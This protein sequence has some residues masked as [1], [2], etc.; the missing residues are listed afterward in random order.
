[1]SEDNVKDLQAIRYSVKRDRWIHTSKRAKLTTPLPTSFNVLTWNVQ[2]DA[3][4]PIRRLTR[5]L[6]H[7][8]AEVLKCEKKQKPEPCCILLQEVH[9]NAFEVF[10]VSEWVQD[11]FV[12]VPSSP[13]RWPNRSMYGTVTLVS[14]TIPLVAAH[15]IE[16]ATSKMARTAMYTDLQLGFPGKEDETVTFRVCN[17]HL[18]S[19]MLTKTRDHQM[20]VIADLVNDAEGGLRGG[21][22]AG[23]MNA[24]TPSD[25]SLPE[26]FGLKDAWKGKQKAGDDDE[27]G[28][29]WGFQNRG[30]FPPARMDKVL[31]SPAPG[32]T[33]A[34]PHVVCVG[35]K[36]REEWVSDH[37][38]LLARVRLVED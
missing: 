16:F 36:L 28:F 6:T 33:V 23:D 34:Q 7:I 19:L 25:M 30:Q 22:V 9:L 29:T 11:N 17:T 24:L 35:V 5:A 18:E 31:Y 12:V 13:H 37:Y 10:L 21:L 15:Q 8:R 2:H 20:R 26:K 4:D 1:M 27:E 14:R 3:P 38:G 32:F